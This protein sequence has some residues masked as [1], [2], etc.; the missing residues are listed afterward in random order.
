MDEK[1]DARKLSLEVLEEKRRQAHRL[2]KRGMTRAEI[3]E[4]VGIHADTIGRWLKRDKNQL[5]YDKPGRKAG[6]GRRL[7]AEQEQH[8]ESVLIDKTPDQ[9][10]MPYALWTRESVRELILNCYGLALPVRTVGDYLKR[11]GMTPQ[12]PQKRAYEQRA[13]EVKAWLE[14]EYPAIK[15][16]A[17]Q[18]NAEIYWGD[19]TGLRNDCQH[20]RGYAP[21]GKTP[22]IRL[23]AKRESCNMISA[24]TNQGK[25][26][27]QIFEGN[28]NADR[29]I[30]FMMRLLKDA[31][32]KVFL[33]LDN[34][35]V[36]HAKPVKEWLEAHKKMIQVFYLP[37][38][39]PELNPDE[40]LNCDLKGGV[41]SGQPARNKEQLKQKVSKHMRMLQR[42][43][44]RVRKY[45]KHEKIRYAA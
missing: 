4:I 20:E 6:S 29:L 19:E 22:V 7:T 41:H 14:E 12:K 39:S 36:H 16:Q 23:N 33:I 1:I 25:V 13:P 24:V 38:Y 32:R 45:F 15:V 34:L 26:R 18:Q 31:K 44:H 10:K 5:G 28:M 3:G 2:R 11:W 8:I 30:D 9:L 42:K 17:K 35:R 43:P 40:Y 21:K 27:Y 37:A